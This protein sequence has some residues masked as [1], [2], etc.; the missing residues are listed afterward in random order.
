MRRFLTITAGALTVLFLVSCM[1]SADSDA[2]YSV[3]FGSDSVG[4]E[5]IVFDSNGG[6]GGYAQYVLNG[7]DILF[8]SEYKGDGI[9]DL[10]YPKIERNGYVLTGWSEDRV[11][12]DLTY[13]PGQ[14]YTVVGDRTFYAVWKD[15]TYDCVGKVSG[16]T[17]DHE[18]EAQHIL[19]LMGS[20]VDLD[21]SKDYGSIEIML[22]ASDRTY[23]KYTL[24]VT[25]NGIARSSELD[26]RTGIVSADWLTATFDAGSFSFSGFPG[27]SGIY[28]ISLNL[29]TKRVG[30]S[31]GDLDNLTCRWYVSCVDAENDASD[32]LYVTYDGEDIGYGPY[33]TAVKLPDSVTQRQKGWNIVVDGSSAVFPVGGAY[34]L[35]KKETVLTVNE[36]T[37]DEVAGSSVVG[38]VAYNANGG[39]YNGPFAE[40]VPVDG[41]SGLKNG[42]VVSKEGYVFLGWNITGSSDDPI[43][44]AGYLYDF[45]DTYTELKAVWGQESC[46][47]AKIFLVNPGDGMQ[48]TSF[49]AFVGFEYMLPV[50][51]FAVSGHVFMGWSVDRYEV[52]SGIPSEGTSVSV[53]GNATY[54]AVFEHS[55][56]SFTIGFDPNGGSGNMDDL[57][58]ESDSVPYYMTLP[59]CSFVLDGYNFIGWS[60]TRY[61]DSASYLPGGTYCFTD[62]E[63]VVLYAV[64]SKIENTD[65]N[66]FSVIFNGNGNGVTNVPPSIYRITSASS[67]SVFI[68]SSVPGREGYDFRGWSDT[69]FGE[70]VYN[71]GQKTT[72]SLSQGETSCTLIL[73]AV[74]E[75]KGVYEGDGTKV[76]V[77]FVGDSGTLRTI[78]VNS[79]STVYPITAPVIDSRSFLGWYGTSGLWDFSDPVDS[80]MVLTAKYVKVFHLSVQGTLVTV[81][82]DCVFDS[83]KVVFSDGFTD[84]YHTSSIPPHEVGSVTDGTVTVTV[85]TESGTFTAVC[86]Y[87]VGDPGNGSD[88]IDIVDEGREI[89]RYVAIFI[90]LIVIVCVVRRLI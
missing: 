62:S 20:S 52:G 43:Y 16:N 2:S 29:K 39:Y 24:T 58:A 73:C 15:L 4:A 19:V 32:V 53:S 45:I 50:N 86:G 33:H 87:S 55:L 7:N 74:W 76:T 70:V 64:W 1:I 23:L 72:L 10:S 67:V 66:L 47:S 41:Y 56:Y 54:Y 77:T 88:E 27:G 82:P 14:S 21:T 51:G 46:P 69:P 18:T 42:S 26:S 36:Y 34:S 22:S 38:A 17:N 85:T 12:S 11:A 81:I 61:S 83:L 35:V 9:S 3:T 89:I 79:G 80:D 8:P 28:E 57:Y 65:D 75:K 25:S 30:G 84:E 59:G 49:D 48:N 44:P 68:P 5:R 13:H 31:Y 63:D 37:F 60:E 6:S 71:P 40:I 90:V 78:E